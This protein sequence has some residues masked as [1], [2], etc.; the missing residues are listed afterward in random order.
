MEILYYRGLTMEILYS[1][2]APQDILIPSLSDRQNLSVRALSSLSLTCCVPRVP[3]TFA[4]LA[5]T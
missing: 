4:P 5:A 1:A 2:D 3:M